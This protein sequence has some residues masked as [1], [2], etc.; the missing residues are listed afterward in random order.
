MHTCTHAHMH[1]CAHA[2]SRA[3]TCT[4]NIHMLGAVTQGTCDAFLM[5]VPRGDER[6]QLGYA[7]RSH[8]PV[9][10]PLVSRWLRSEEPPWETDTSTRQV[11]SGTDNAHNLSSA[12]CQPHAHA[13]AR[14]REHTRART[15][16]HVHTHTHTITHAHAHAHITSHHTHTQTHKPQA[17]S[18]CWFVCDH[19]HTHAR[20][21][22]CTRTHAR[23]HAHAHAPCTCTHTQ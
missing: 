15:H 5:A 16:T 20:M 6:C 14:A 17:L 3:H 7:P 8:P 23:M 21:H 13:H 4:C 2:H 9:G 18:L 22:A 12:T 1:T 10:I 11:T 19:I